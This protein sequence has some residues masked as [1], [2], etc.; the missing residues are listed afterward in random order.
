MPIADDFKRRQY[1]ALR[2][3]ARFDE[4]AWQSKLEDA[5]LIL[6]MKH[7]VMGFIEDTKRSPESLQNWLKPRMVPGDYVSIRA[8][9]LLGAEAE[10][11]GALAEKETLRAENKLYN[12]MFLA[13]YKAAQ[14]TREGH[15]VQLEANATANLKYGGHELD[16]AVL[17][18]I[19]EV[20]EYRRAAGFDEASLT[21]KEKI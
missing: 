19:A 16:A 20:R 3:G 10:L 7:K 2:D 4:Q 12:E 17:R 21:W 15:L 6:K 8:E 1:S 18:L 14:A 13:G 5:R 11:A 9:E